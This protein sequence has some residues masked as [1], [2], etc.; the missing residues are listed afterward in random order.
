MNTPYFYYAKTYLFLYIFIIEG[1]KIT[2]IPNLSSKNEFNIEKFKVKVEIPLK[3]SHLISRFLT[4]KIFKI[5]IYINQKK[6]IFMC[7]IFRTTK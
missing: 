7:K 2:I 6:Y 4:L 5:Y 3:I 1:E